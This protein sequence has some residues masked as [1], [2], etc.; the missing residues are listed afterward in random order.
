[1]AGMYIAKDIFFLDFSLGAT[2]CRDYDLWDELKKLFDTLHNSS[3]FWGN[4]NTLAADTKNIVIAIDYITGKQLGF[5][6]ALPDKYTDTVRVTFIEAFEKR[7]HIGS[8]LIEYLDCS[9]TGRSIVIDHPLEDSY[10]FWSKLL[11]EYPTMKTNDRRLTRFV[12]KYPNEIPHNT[13]SNWRRFQVEDPPHW[14][15][16]FDECHYQ[17]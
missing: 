11:N 16:C 17:L 10:P 13:N 1:M 6:Y 14:T 9:R 8:L 3:E 15:T 12:N 7:K 5:L 4:R 2:L